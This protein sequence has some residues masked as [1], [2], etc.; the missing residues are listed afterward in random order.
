[1]INKIGYACINLSLGKSVTTNRG[2]TQKTLLSRGTD[3]VSELAL[4]NCQDVIKILKWNEQNGIKMFR[5]SSCLIPWGNVVDI[6]E[7]RDIDQIRSVLKEAGDYAHEHDIRITTHP[8]PFT[9]IASTNNTVVVNAIKDL[10][11][12]AKVFDLMGLSKTPYNKINIHVNTTTDGKLESMKRFCDAYWHLSDS[13]RSRLVVENDDKPK[14]YTVEDLIFIHEQIGIPI[15]F[16]YFH[17]SLN[18]GNLTE[19]DALKLAA[20]TWPKGI[21]QAVH[22]SESKR[23]HENN[24]KENA[25]A[26][27]DYIN[28]LPETY[29]VEI[30]VM[31][32]CKMKD[33]ALLPH[34][35][36]I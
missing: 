1:M 13:V 7:L 31:T 24:N 15:T 22:Y 5:L 21:T 27:S 12:H 4:K 10:E 36:N 33:L 9:V 29:G 20:T 34:L 23:L 3:Y 18:P 30:D 26:H 25:R 16:D 19:E 8:G 35:K 6:D 14:Q 28:S 17:H 11:M 2:M 32:E